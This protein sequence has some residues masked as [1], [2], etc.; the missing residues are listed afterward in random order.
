MVT[1]R[2]KATKSVVS[3]CA[4]QSTENSSV[5]GGQGQDRTVDLPLFRRDISPVDPGSC[6][7]YA[8]AAVAAVSRWLLLLLSPLLSAAGPVPCLRGLPGAVTASCPPSEVDCLAVIFT[9]QDRERDAELHERTLRPADMS[10]HL[11]VHG[12]PRVST[13]VVSTAWQLASSSPKPS[14]PAVCRAAARLAWDR[15]SVDVRWRPPLSVAIVTHFVTRWLLG[16][17]IGPA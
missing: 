4:G 7:C 15:P 13:A 6:E 16:L 10:G 8:L 3:I 5:S 9:G 11:G 1:R 17:F 2:L 12:R 14:C